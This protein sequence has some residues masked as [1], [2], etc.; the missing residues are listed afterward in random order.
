MEGY[1][2]VKKAAEKL[3]ISTTAVYKLIHRGS[4]A[5]RR[6][7]MMLWI[8]DEELERLRKDPQYRRYSRARRDAIGDQPE[9]GGGE[10]GTV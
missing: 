4:L 3:G 1:K 6:L 10:N 2:S 5:S 7:G 8:K 9:L